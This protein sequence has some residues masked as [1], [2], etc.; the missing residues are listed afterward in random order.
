MIQNYKASTWCQP[1]TRGGALTTSRSVRG[2]LSFSSSRN[3]KPSSLFP[4]NKALCQKYEKWDIFLL[5]RNPFAIGEEKMTKKRKFFS[6]SEKTFHS[7]STEMKVLKKT[8]KTPGF[9][10]PEQ[11]RC[12]DTYPMTWIKSKHNFSVEAHWWTQYYP[13]QLGIKSIKR[14]RVH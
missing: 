2:C 13:A 9:H 10:N 5:S 14:W 11:C 1:L 4:W 6:F 8:T 3:T 7:F 12:Y